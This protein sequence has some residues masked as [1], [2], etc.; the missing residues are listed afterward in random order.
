MH[1]TGWYELNKIHISSDV[2]D[3][4]S[5]SYRLS[6]GI[7][8]RTGFTRSIG[9][10]WSFKKLSI[11]IVKNMDSRQ[12]SQTGRVTTQKGGGGSVLKTVKSRASST[13]MSKYKSYFETRQE[14]HRPQ[15]NR[16][17]ALLSDIQTAVTTNSEPNRL[18]I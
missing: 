3:K 18:T 9:L 2:C 7:C 10:L 1:S 17:I 12:T 16:P 4:R 5:D 13:S 15:K 6:E 8:Q 14:K 11:A